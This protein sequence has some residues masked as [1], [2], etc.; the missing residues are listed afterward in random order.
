VSGSL[1]KSGQFVYFIVADGEVSPLNKFNSSG[2][3]HPAPRTSHLAPRT[4][5]LAPRTSHVQIWRRT[6]PN[7]SSL[8]FFKIPFRG[9]RRQLLLLPKKRQPSEKDNDT[10][11]DLN[12]ESTGEEAEEEEEELG[13]AGETEVSGE[14]DNL[15]PLQEVKCLWRCGRVS[16]GEAARTVAWNFSGR[17]ERAKW[18]G[19]GD[20]SGATQPVWTPQESARG[21][22]LFCPPFAGRTGSLE[23]REFVSGRDLASSARS[24]RWSAGFEVQAAVWLKS[25]LCAW[26]QAMAW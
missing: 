8:R 22:Q 24:A 6:R 3:S 26:R 15:Y 18:P 20:T 19:G 7:R 4:S 13:P 2:A 12:P 23:E 21:V 25:H 9:G 10:G 5:H 1:E 16:A 17:A 14:N 11:T